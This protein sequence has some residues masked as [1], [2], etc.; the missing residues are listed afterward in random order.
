MRAITCDQITQAVSEYN[1]DQTLKDD[2]ARDA[3]AALQAL[4]PSLGRFLAEVCLVADWGSIPLNGFPFRDRVAMA[5]EIRKCW[6]DVLQPLQSITAGDWRS[7]GSKNLL[8]ALFQTNLPHPNPQ[9]KRQLVFVSKYLHWCVNPEFAILDG[10]SQKALGKSSWKE[11]ANVK[12]LWAY[13]SEWM[14]EIREQV[15]VHQSCLE[16]IRNDDP[17]IVRTLD[18]ALYILGQEDESEAEK[19]TKRVRA[20]TENAHGQFV[21]RNTG[22]LSNDRSQNIYQLVCLKCGH[23]YGTQRG[24]VHSQKCPNCQNGKPGLAF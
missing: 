3:V 8:E 16:G 22:K 12:E 6:E 11:N 9:S 1:N 2:A 21:V 17:S 20:K 24:D 14:H 5:E 18:K 4:P 23:N 15:T 13:Y 7:D 10:N 19:E